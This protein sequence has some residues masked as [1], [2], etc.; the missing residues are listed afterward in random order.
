MP[1]AWATGAPMSSGRRS[2][3]W[4]A[5]QLADFGEQGAVGMDHAFGVGGGAGC[6]RDDCGGIGVDA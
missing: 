2:G 5:R 4:S 1:I 3:S 6:V